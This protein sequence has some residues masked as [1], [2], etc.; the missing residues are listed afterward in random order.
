MTGMTVATTSRPASRALGA[1]CAVALALA[2]CQHQERNSR[3]TPTSGREGATVS[4]TRFPNVH[5]RL[6][7]TV[8]QPGAATLEVDTDV[9][10]LGDRF[11]VRDSRG[12]SPAQIL[13][14]LAYPRGT[15]APLRTMEEL[16]DRA[17][18]VSRAPRGVTELYG[19]LSTDRGLVLQPLRDPSPRSATELAPA[20][21]Q[22]L[23]D[24]RLTGLAAG[25]ESAHL[26]RNAI[27]YRGALEGQEEGRPYRTELHRLVAAPYLLREEARDAASPQALFLVREVTL[28]EEGSVTEGDVTPPAR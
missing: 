5:A 22:V 26:G 15:G 11:R 23:A 18:E 13:D 19:D 12:R 27:L 16:M 1:W 20:A 3:S 4:A 10:L 6:H 25:A 28:L 24:G 8:A 7:T 17:S 14:E 9:W 21:T 2:G